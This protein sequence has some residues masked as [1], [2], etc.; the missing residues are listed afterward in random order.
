MRLTIISDS[1]TDVLLGEFLANVMKGMATVMG[2]R[3]VRRV[4]RR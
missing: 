1:E 3:V 4:V 2:T